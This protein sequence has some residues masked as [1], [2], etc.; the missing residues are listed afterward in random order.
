MITTLVDN[1][2]AVAVIQAAVAVVA[3]MG[4]LLIARR[5]GVSLLGEASWAMLRGFVQVVIVGSVLAVL[6]RGPWW[7]AILV[8]LGMFA[9]AASIARKRAKA[10]PGAYQLILTSLLIGAGSVI[11][12]MALL[13]VLDASVSN[14]VPVGSMLLSNAM[15]ACTLM[16]ERL[17]SDVVAHRATSRAQALPRRV[18]RRLRRAVRRDR[19]ADRDDPAGQHHDGTGHRLHPRADVRHGAGRRRPPA[20]G[21]IYR[22]VVIALILAAGGLHAM[23]AAWCDRLLRPAQQL[24]VREA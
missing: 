8:L 21:A 2:W 19:G 7:T 9:A 17:R 14:L 11:V 5:Y 12:V 1:T 13:G 23:V 6:L 3:V 16:L 4:V 24:V 15:T 10:I 20:G 22:F 18:T